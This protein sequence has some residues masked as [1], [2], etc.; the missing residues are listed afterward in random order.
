MSRWSE[1][2]EGQYFQ[3]LDR[4]DDINPMLILSTFKDNSNDSY[5]VV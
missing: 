4:L 3:S 5:A 1:F 2:S